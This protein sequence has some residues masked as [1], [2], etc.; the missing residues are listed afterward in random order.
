ML[1]QGTEMDNEQK[2]ISFLQEIKSIV[3]HGWHIEP[4]LEQMVLKNEYFFDN[5]IDNLPPALR[6][7]TYLYYH[8]SLTYSQIAS[9]LNTPA[10]IVKNRL[11]ISLYLLK[12]FI[13][14]HKPPE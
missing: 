1:Q 13:V 12:I 5:L 11:R 10:P 9:V 4:R 6:K 7:T 2:I 3:T 14:K 8:R